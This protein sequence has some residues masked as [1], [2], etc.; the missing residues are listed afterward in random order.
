[1]DITP[2]IDSG[3]QLINSY[4][5]GAFRV[6]G[7]TYTGSLLLFP[8]EVRSLAVAG[9]ADLEWEH[10]AAVVE[11]TPPVELL[12]VGGGVVMAEPRPEIR[13]GLRAAGI[14]MEIMDTG[15]ACRTYNVLLAEDRR[16]AAVLV[17]V[18]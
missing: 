14:V 5:D 7:Q 15:A 11:A 18:D 10:L 2:Q 8:A 4:G 17:A 13:E 1:M 3:R 6:S 16:I 9:V 12:L